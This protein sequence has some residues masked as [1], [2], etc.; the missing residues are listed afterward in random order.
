LIASET[1]AE[2][3]MKVAGGH[4]VRMKKSDVVRREKQVQSLMPAGLADGMSAQEL[5]DV[6]AYLGGLKP[7]TL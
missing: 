6:L 7:P 1:E 3:V 5:A 2:L 4:R